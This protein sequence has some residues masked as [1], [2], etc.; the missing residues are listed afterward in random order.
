MLDYPA[1]VIFHAEPQQDP[2]YRR[3]CE[4]AGAFAIAIYGDPIPDIHIHT[5]CEQALVE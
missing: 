2:V 4:E 5:D 3:A 1:V